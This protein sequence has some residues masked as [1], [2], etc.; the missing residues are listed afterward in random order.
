M[1]LPW[2]CPE[3]TVD[4]PVCARPASIPCRIRA[5]VALGMS[6]IVKTDDNNAR[7]AVPKAWLFLSVADSVIAGVGVPARPRSDSPKGDRSESVRHPG[8]AG[9]VAAVGKELK[10][11]IAQLCAPWGQ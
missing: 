11:L 9:N 2:L 7:P 10:L 5:W 6:R 1:Y 4:M 8:N 3:Q